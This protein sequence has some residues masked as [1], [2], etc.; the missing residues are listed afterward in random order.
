MIN[1]GIQTRIGALLKGTM[2]ARDEFEKFAQG[3]DY[4]EI[5]AAFDDDMFASE[6]RSAAT[7][8]LL[9]RASEAAEIAAREA[10]AA[11]DRATEAAERSARWTMVAAIASAV[12]AIAAAAAVVVP[13]MIQKP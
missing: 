1:Q 10:R 12:G 3:R 4:I 8:W 6:A 13:L 2:Y 5:K 11:Q 9:R 7:H